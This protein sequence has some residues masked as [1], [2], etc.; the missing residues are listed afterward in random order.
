MGLGVGLKLTNAVYAPALCLALFALDANWRRRLTAAASFGC[1][2]LGGIAISAGHWFWKMWT[3]FGNPLF[4]QFNDRF[5]G[6]LALP[7][8][9]GDSGWLP[10]G[11]LE[12]LLWPFIFTLHP[13]RISELPLRHLIW[14]LLYLALL[15]LALAGLLSLLRAARSTSSP[16]PALAPRSR[17]LLT[18]LVVSYLIWQNLFSI[19]RYLLPLELLAPL[20]FW[21]VTARLAPRPGARRLAAGCLAL[22]ACSFLSSASW[23]HA[24]RS[25]HGFTVQTPALEQPQASMVFTVQADPPL[26]W[27]VPFFPDS[28]AFVSIGA[29]FPESQAYR[30]RV[31]AMRRS[32]SAAHYLMLSADLS[33]QALRGSPEQIA[34][35]AARNQALLARSAATLA[36]YGMR[37]DPASCRSYQAA[38]GRNRYAYQLCLLQ[39]AP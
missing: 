24:G 6:P 12:Q 28:L 38:V 27:L 22:A 5:L 33:E 3:V 29:G 14:P 19:Y 9:I 31:A 21:L 39:D 11:W 7:I 20:A 10:R 32:R 8:G 34:Q 35:A 25:L 1:G 18:F 15:G 13:K 26:G 2:V 30:D 16:L 37:F 17:L 4:P 23:G 36:N